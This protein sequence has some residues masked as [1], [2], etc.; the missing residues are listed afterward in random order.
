MNPV[1]LGAWLLAAVAGR[2]MMLLPGGS[3]A[4]PWDCAGSREGVCARLG[5]PVLP[6]KHRAGMPAAQEK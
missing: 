3:V 6:G 5:T 4:A 2:L 1:C